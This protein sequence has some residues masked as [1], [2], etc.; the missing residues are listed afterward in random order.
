MR[1]IVRP[2]A[3]EDVESAARWY[4]E[5]ATGLGAEFLD[6]LNRRLEDIEEAPERFPRVSPRLRRAM[7]ERFPYSIFFTISRG[8]IQ[9]VACMHG[10]RHPARWLRRG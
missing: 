2:L 1:L 9:V 5:Q 8:A 4:E 3:A 6:A 7:L 10:R